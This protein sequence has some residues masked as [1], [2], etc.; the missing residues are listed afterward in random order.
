MRQAATQ[1]DTKNIVFVPKDWGES[2]HGG[3]DDGQHGASVCI[4][5]LLLSHEY[6]L[7]GI[8]EQTFIKTD[9][10]GTIRFKV[11]VDDGAGWSNSFD[12]T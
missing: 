11:H 5:E 3:E 1:N 8:D 10:A 9:S 6:R 12:S 2:S 4:P 7:S